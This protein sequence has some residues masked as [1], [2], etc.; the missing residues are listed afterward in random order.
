MLDILSRPL[1]GRAAAAVAGQIAV[2]DELAELLLQRV[3]AGAGVA[4]CRWCSPARAHARNRGCAPTAPA[5]AQ[6]GNVVGR[7]LV[8]A[9]M[10]FIL[11]AVA[12]EIAVQL[13]DT[14]FG[15]GC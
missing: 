10:P 11:R 13:P 3:A 5:V 6:R 9:A 12:Q 14:V 1:P 7:F 4:P 2:L 15:E 8:A